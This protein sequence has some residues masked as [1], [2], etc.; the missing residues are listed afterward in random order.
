MRLLNYV[1]GRG[2]THIRFPPR[3]EGAMI[4]RCS[5]NNMICITGVSGNGAAMGIIY[6]PTD[7]PAGYR[8]LFGT[9]TY[10]G[11]EHPIVRHGSNFITC[12]SLILNDG[13]IK[14]NMRYSCPYTLYFACIS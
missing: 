2:R 10:N 12:E 1:S 3:K 11:A 5:I 6:Y 8:F 14:Y 7:V 9:F 13:S 4:A